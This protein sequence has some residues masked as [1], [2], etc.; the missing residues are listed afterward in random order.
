MIRSVFTEKGCNQESR[1]EVR[2]HSKQSHESGQQQ[3]QWEERDYALEVVRRHGLRRIVCNIY[4]YG[5]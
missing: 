3:E 2:Y 5:D 1:R 4:V